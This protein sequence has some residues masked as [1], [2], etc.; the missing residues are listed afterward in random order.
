V[1]LAG[2]RPEKFYLIAQ[3]KVSVLAPKTYAEIQ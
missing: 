1:F 3:G 2:E